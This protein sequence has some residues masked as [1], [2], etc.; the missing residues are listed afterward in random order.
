MQKRG[1]EREDVVDTGGYEGLGTGGASTGITL[2]G[3]RLDLALC[4]FH[5]AFVGHLV[6]SVFTAANDLAGVAVAGATEG[7]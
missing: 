6:E 1:D 7:G 5:I 3:V 4:D 2:V